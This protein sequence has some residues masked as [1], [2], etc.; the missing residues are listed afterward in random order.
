MPTLLLS[1][2]GTVDS[3]QLRH[4]AIALGWSV[5]RL[6]EVEQINTYIGK[7]SIATFGEAVF[8]RVVAK[9]LR[10]HLLQPPLNWITQLPASYLQRRLTYTTLAEAW[11]Q[12]VPS[13]IK[14]A[15]EK[16]FAAKIHATGTELAYES[17]LSEATPVFVVEP[18]KWEIEFRCFVLEGKPTAISVYKRNGE[19]ARDDSGNWNASDIELRQTEEF[20]IK[21][22]SDMRGT[23]PPAFVL[24]IGVIENV[25]WAVIETNPAWASGIY[26]CNPFNILPVLQRSCRSNIALA[27]KDKQ[28]VL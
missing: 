13:F 21:V 24:D 26:G 28:W 19:L 5:D 27:P 15:G 18:V 3:I 25:G 7:S 22:L 11:K 1:S 9:A 10:L 4:A 12:T 14:P 6:L 17:V 20:C 8:A 2:R 23:S 16:S